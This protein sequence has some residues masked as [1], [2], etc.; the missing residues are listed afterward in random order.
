MI[1]RRADL[2]RVAELI[3]G[4]A[5]Q[6]NARGDRAW[7]L[8]R[9]WTPGAGASTLD[10]GRSRTL[11]DPT[12][13]AA[14]A[15]TPDPHAAMLDAYNRLVAAARE[16]EQLLRDVGPDPRPRCAWHAEGGYFA[17]ATRTAEHALVCEWCYRRH[18]STGK[19]PTF[20]HLHQRAAGAQRI[21]RRPA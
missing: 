19:R 9:D 17:P 3:R 18:A 7:Q 10:T 2:A 8:T 12:S 21:P 15:H 1:R 13:R 20:A 5:D 11:G 4:L 16:I 6:I 14:L